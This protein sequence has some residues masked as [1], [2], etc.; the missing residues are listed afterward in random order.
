MPISSSHNRYLPK[1]L[2]LTGSDYQI[3]VR[4]NGNRSD[5]RQITKRGRHLTVR[6]PNPG[7]NLTVESRADGFSY[8]KHGAQA[9]HVRDTADRVFIQG[10]NGQ[11]TSI[12]KSGNRIFVDRAGV[13]KDVVFTQTNNG[14]NIDRY[15]AN[16]DVSIQRRG[17]NIEFRY[18]QPL[19]NTRVTLPEGLD[20]DPVAYQQ[21]TTVDPHA[22]AVVD[23]WFETGR[24]SAK[25]LIFI[26][27][28]GDLVETF[29]TL[30]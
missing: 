30:R 3:T 2:P 9:T 6:S 21:E 29:N 26:T 20:F 15:G 4:R 12:T 1:A 18:G 11:S 23:K 17:Q 14:M 13:S 25:D 19:R 5:Q 28:R 7:K 10:A 22:M 8:S 27:Q 24:L 16:N